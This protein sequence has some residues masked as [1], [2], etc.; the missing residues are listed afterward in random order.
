MLI[1]IAQSLSIDRCQHGRGTGFAQFV[2]DV[3]DEIGPLAR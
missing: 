3:R 2:E 1:E